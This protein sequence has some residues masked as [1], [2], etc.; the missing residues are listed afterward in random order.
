MEL[1]K[2]N[3][4]PFGLP[5]CFFTLLSGN[6][7]N[8]KYPWCY[9]QLEEALVAHTFQREPPFWYGSPQGGKYLANAL[10]NTRS[11]VVKCYA[12]VKAETGESPP[13]SS[14]FYP[15]PP[16]QYPSHPPVANPKFQPV[17][18]SSVVKRE[19]V[20]PVARQSD[21]PSLPSY[22]QLPEGGK[23]KYHLVCDGKLSSNNKKVLLKARG[24]VDSA[25]WLKFKEVDPLLAYLFLVC[26]GKEKMVDVVVPVTWIGTCQLEFPACV[27]NKT[28]D[29]KKTMADLI[30]KV[31]P[32]YVVPKPK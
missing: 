6:L 22:L 30:K 16:Q 24:D 13:T 9:F 12:D 25:E 10:Q 5:V 23:Q 18:T 11:Y 21:L 20:Q 17:T 3:I 27:V 4:A 31:H 8:R 32:E 14:S 19:M 15:N 2:T 1:D 26:C 7:C 28:K 29:M